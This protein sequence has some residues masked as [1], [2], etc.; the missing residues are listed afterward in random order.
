MDLS[1]EWELDPNND[2]KLIIRKNNSVV[3]QSDF[4]SVETKTQ[5]YA[6]ET[7]TSPM[8]RVTHT[9]E[10]SVHQTEE[11]LFNRNKKRRLNPPE[12]NS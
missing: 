9:A 3:T 2:G 12:T 6:S 11:I 4:I 1:F 5:I 7:S 10:T 8:M